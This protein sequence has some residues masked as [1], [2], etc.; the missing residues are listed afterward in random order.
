MFSNTWAGYETNESLNLNNDQYCAP[1]SSSFADFNMDHLN[2]VYNEDML[3]MCLKREKNRLAATKC[4]EKKKEKLN[5]LML[6]AEHLERGNNELR[7]ECY[8]LEAEK[9]YLVKMLMERS[10]EDSNSLD[11]KMGNNECQTDQEINH[12]EIK[13]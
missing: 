9:R 1:T 11:I 13:Y 5:N 2:F 4:R 6:T 12:Q 7:Q 10:I 3:K 8:R